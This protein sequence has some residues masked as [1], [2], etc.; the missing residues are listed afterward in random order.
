MEDEEGVRQLVSTILKRQGFKVLEAR[1]GMEALNL[2][3]HYLEPVHL[4]LTDIVMPGMGGQ[5]LVQHV[6]TI[7]P[8]IK[9]LYMSGYTEQTSL[10]QG[11]SDLEHCYLQKPFEAQGLLKRVREMLDAPA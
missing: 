6:K 11:L 1:H 3:A 8:E 9:V 10:H 4:I 7:H 2:V 5:E